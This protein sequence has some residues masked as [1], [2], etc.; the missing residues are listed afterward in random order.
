MKIR[1]GFVSNS[2][3]SSFIVVFEEVPHNVDELQKMLF[4]DE[5]FYY[6]PFNGTYEAKEIAQIVFNDM[7][8]GIPSIDEISENFRV[9]LYDDPR[10]KDSS[11]QIDFDKLNE[12]EAKES[13][14][15]FKKFM[16]DIDGVGVAYIFNYGDENGPREADMEH[17]DLF[18]NLK[19][20]RINNH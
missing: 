12:V 17:G 16:D 1:N 2:S 10:V 19:H 4:M 13:E 11:G 3:S 6:G 18:K 15:E 5:D 20:I 7:K 9:D 14:K 8:D